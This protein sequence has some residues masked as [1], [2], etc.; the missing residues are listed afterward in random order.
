MECR[1]APRRL[2]EQLTLVFLLLN[3]VGKTV[4][5]S[6]QWSWKLLLNNTGVVA[7]HMAVTHDNNVVIFDQTEAGPSAYR[8]RRQRNGRKCETRDDASCYAHSVEY[9]VLKNRVRALHLAT[10]TWCSSGSF[11][12]NG[13]SF[14]RAV[15]GWGREMSGIFGRV[16]IT[17]VIGR[18]IGSSYRFGGGTLRAYISH[19]R[20]GVIVVGGRSAF[21][22]E[23]VPKFSG[24]G[25]PYNLGLLHQTYERNSK[26][27]NLYPILH[28]SSDGNLFIFANRDS[29]L[30]DY[31]RH[32]VLKK[33]PRIPG[34]GGR[35]YPSTGSSVILPLDHS[36][37]FTKVEVMVCGGAAHGSYVATRQRRYLTGLRSCGRMVITGNHHR[38]RMENMPGP[39][40]MSDMLVLPTGDILIVNGAKRG[41]AGWNRASSPALEPYLYKPKQSAGRRFQVL[42]QTKISRLYHSSAV[43]LPDGRILVAGG[44]PNSRYIMR[45][46]A[47]P[48]ELRL[49]ALVPGYMSNRFDRLRPKNVTV[50]YPQHSTGVKNG[51]TFD[52]NFRL[53]AESGNLSIVAYAPPFATHSLSM[54]QRLLRL[55][56]LSLESGGQGLMEAKVV[57]PPSINV[58]PPG[59][60]MLTVVNGGI[61]SRSSW[62]KII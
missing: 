62:V 32:K 18:N 52:V 60:Y 10:D 41:C 59:F 42:K 24:S 9:N 55:E 37:N 25:G 53:A 61:P 20:T 49:Q 57:A 2:V 56:Y 46:V 51:E 38:W 7:M 15:T 16:L 34:D 45:R 39:R 1:R 22:Y 17:D 35:S 36:D 27:N 29:I 28:L 14:R 31:K 13:V 33:F 43:L 21:S 40:L 26:G 11:L 6:S 54:N 12:S 58:A 30:F 48:T 8:L 44:N 4:G 23:F 5:V 19:G 47:H 3:H 50:A